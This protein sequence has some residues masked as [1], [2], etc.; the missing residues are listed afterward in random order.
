MNALDL[1]IRDGLVV[2]ETAVTRADVGIAGG[3]IAALEPHIT[4]TARQTIAAAGLHVFPGVI[5]AHVHFNEPDA[6]IGKGSKPVRA[7]W[8]RAAARFFSTCP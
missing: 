6:A 8:L 1:I 3:K 5:D 4:D 7:P 2:T